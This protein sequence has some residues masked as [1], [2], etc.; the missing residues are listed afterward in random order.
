MKANINTQYC[1]WVYVIPF[2]PLSGIKQNDYHSYDNSGVNV[3]FRNLENT[4]PTPRICPVSKETTNAQISNRSC[5]VRVITFSIKS[6]TVNFP[7]FA[8]MGQVKGLA[9]R[10]HQSNPSDKQHHHSH[11][12]K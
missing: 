2:I 10:I 3:N 4:K 7:I 11:Q 1:A 6:G 5:G 9:E 8:D 12:R